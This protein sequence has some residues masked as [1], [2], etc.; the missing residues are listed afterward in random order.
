MKLYL[1]DKELC[2]IKEHQ[3]KSNVYYFNNY[4]CIDIIGD[5][6][7]FLG[8]DNSTL[9]IEN[10]EIPEGYELNIGDVVSFKMTK[11]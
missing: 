11:E 2:N 1:Y 8:D 9:S 6:Y 10:L 5:E 3:F 7:L 4:T